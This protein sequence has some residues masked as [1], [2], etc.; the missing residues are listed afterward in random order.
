MEVVSHHLLLAL[1]LKLNIHD[2]CLNFLPKERKLSPQPFQLQILIR[3][4]FHVFM[5]FD[6][7]EINLVILHTNGILDLFGHLVYLQ[8]HEI[9]EGLKLLF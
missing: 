8:G 7:N 5:Y 1:K 4:S 2:A 9:I 3:L 6:R